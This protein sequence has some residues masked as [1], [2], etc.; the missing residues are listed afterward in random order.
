LMSV[1]PFN[2]RNSVCIS[3]DFSPP[4]SIFHFEKHCFHL[5][6]LRY[7][8]FHRIQ[9]IMFKK[10]TPLEGFLSGVLSSLG[11]EGTFHQLLPS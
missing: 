5:I 2:S 7:G 4:I 9:L 8:L 6:I 1:Q 11:I 10:K 3:L